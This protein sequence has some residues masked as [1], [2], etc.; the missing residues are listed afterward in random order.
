MG[1]G[2]LFFFFLFVATIVF[3]YLAVRR[4]LLAP[5]MIGALCIGG[6][7]VFIL[8][9]A[10]AQGAIFLH[11]LLVGVVIGG[12]FGL[13]TLAV[14]LYFQGNELRQQRPSA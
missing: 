2:A 1:I 14:A 12:A 11:A 5:V 3:S 7:V 13:A 6:S 9:F 10:L 8:L 4:R